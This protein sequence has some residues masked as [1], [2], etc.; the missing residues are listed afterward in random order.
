M[1]LLVAFLA[2]G[3]AVL[4]AGLLLFVRPPQ[5]D[6]H[7]VDAV[8]VPAGGAGERL[9]AASALMDEGAATVLV[10]SHGPSTLCRMEDTPYEV[11]CFVPDPG[12]TRGE[13]Q[14]IGRLAEERGWDRVAVVTST[15][16]VMRTR[17]LVGQCV[18]GDV[19][20][21]DAGSAFATNER[22]LRAIRHEAAGLI[23]ALVL[24][25]AC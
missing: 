3:L 2:L 20:M 21:V 1:R 8:A 17:V 14:E 7:G 5:G 10:L 23:A 16:H 9:R 19:E 18:D 13:A 4:L 12:N 25:P 22:R 15:Q 24:E 6:P 11:V